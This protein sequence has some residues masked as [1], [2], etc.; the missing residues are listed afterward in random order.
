MKKISFTLLALAT[1]FATAGIMPAAPHDDEATLKQ[2]SAYRQWT[3]INPEPVEVKVTAVTPV[4]ISVGDV[5][6]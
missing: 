2:I 5:A 1:V 3:R 4:S 6:V